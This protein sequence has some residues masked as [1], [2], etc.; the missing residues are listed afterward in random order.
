MNISIDPSDA[1]FY[2]ESNGKIINGAFVKSLRVMDLTN[3]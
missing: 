3:F 2:G 1:E